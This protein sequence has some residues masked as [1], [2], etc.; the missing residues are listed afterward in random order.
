MSL[1]CV[2]GVQNTGRWWR[3]CTNLQ[4]DI[5]LAGE[6]KEGSIESASEKRKDEAVICF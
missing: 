6:K 2:L 4:I 5:S 1:R 3:G